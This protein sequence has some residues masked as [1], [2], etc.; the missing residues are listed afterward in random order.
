[1]KKIAIDTAPYHLD[2][3]ITKS[4]FEK[5][6]N[7][8]IDDTLTLPTGNKYKFKNSYCTLDSIDILNENFFK[9][10]LGTAMWNEMEKIANHT[11][12]QRSKAFIIHTEAFN[13][14]H[15]N[16]TNIKDVLLSK[17]EDKLLF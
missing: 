7:N 6:K 17:M 2:I 1:M 10:G 9:V 3:E 13:M 4:N 16:F 15:I 5:Y 14:A 8:I 12:A 11:T